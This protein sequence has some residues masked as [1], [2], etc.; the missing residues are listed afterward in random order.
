[1]TFSLRDILNRARWRDENLHALELVVL[2]RGA[3]GDR[4]V[5]SGALVTD[6]GPSG[7]TLDGQGLEEDVFLPYHRFLAIRGPDGALWDKEGRALEAHEAE[8][9]EAVIEEAA[10]AVADEAAATTPRTTA[11]NQEA[12]HATAAA[13]SEVATLQATS[14]PDAAGPTPSAQATAAAPTGREIAVRH[15]VVLRHPHRDAPLVIDGS[16]GEGGGQILRTSLTLSMLTGK[17]FVLEHIRGRRSRPGLLRQHLTCVNA[18][19]AVSQA[20]VEGA[21]L[22]SSTL[23]F[24]PGAARGV[25]RRF[26]I[27]S[28]GSV[29]LVLQTIALPLALADRPSTITLRG[30]THAR[31]APIVPFLERAWLPLVRRMGADIALELRRPGFYPAGGGEVV[32]HVSPAASS[33][34]PLHLPCPAGALAVEIDAIVSELP[35]SI[36]RRELAVVA[37]RLGAERVMLR[38]ATVRGVGPGNALWIA[39]RGAGEVTN[40]FSGLGERGVAAED[41]AREVAERFLAW[42][43]SGAAVEEHL[44][45]QLMVPMA[46]ARGGSFTTDAI[47]LHS[48]TNADVIE[49]F[50]GE[51]VRAFDLGDG[52]F[53]VA[54]GDPAV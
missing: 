16:A 3:P 32:M 47:S 52:R 48:T 4:R 37:E 35:E 49:A 1:M 8:D 14:N 9:E 30:G 11:A 20:T 34:A 38:S 12:A 23:S 25:E 6:V 5:V 36:A 21:S 44:T 29:A 39:A 42:R 43:A 17:P 41:V 45:D 24:R 19:A 51:R 53:R 26:D 40:V 10:I 54:L 33:L 7:V 22:G 15:E 2:H 46:L 13:G 50:T 28:A 31:W 18:A 27:G